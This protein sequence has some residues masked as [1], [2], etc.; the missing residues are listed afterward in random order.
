MTKAID[1]LTPEIEYNENAAL[2]SLFFK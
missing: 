1:A 2:K